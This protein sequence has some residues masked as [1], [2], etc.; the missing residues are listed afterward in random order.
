M[1]QSRW[2][3]HPCDYST[4]RKLK[5]LHC[6]YQKAV[7]M[8]HAYSRWQRKD[9]HNR[10]MRR[11]IRNDAGQTIGHEPPVPL[12]EPRLCPIFSKKVLEKRHIDK[13]GT[14]FRDGFLEEKVV[15]DDFGIAAD[16]ASA[17]RPFKELVEVRPI[18]ISVEAIECTFRAGPK[19]GCW[20]K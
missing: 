19:N 14:L 18:S 4:Y 11:R 12:S 1:F 7:R 9:P 17:R 15:T 8:A 6:V 10:V 3:F 20:R 13:K 5:F 2:G 16:F